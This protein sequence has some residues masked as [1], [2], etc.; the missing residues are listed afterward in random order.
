MAACSVRDSSFFLANTTT[1]NIP[2]WTKHTD[3]GHF[4]FQT[5]KEKKKTLYFVTEYKFLFSETL[6]HN[7]LSEMAA[8][9]QMVKKL[10][11]FCT[12]N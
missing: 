9:A 11:A 3:K 12:T 1:C 10:P 6:P 4:R 2:C 8:E 7:H 5:E